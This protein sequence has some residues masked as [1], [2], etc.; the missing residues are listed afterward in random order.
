MTL[1][2]LVI[3]GI[4]AII[5]LN[6]KSKLKLASKIKPITQNESQIMNK[7]FNNNNNN[8]ILKIIDNN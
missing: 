5:L 4:T 1:F 7:S 8:N 3:F 2:V 6:K